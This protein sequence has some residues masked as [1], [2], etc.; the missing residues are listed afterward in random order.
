[1]TLGWRDTGIPGCCSIRMLGHQNAGRP[2]HWDVGMLEHQDSCRSGQRLQAQVPARSL[3]SCRVT[4]G[5]GTAGLLESGSPWGLGGPAVAGPME[6][7]SV[8]LCWVLPTGDSPAPLPTRDPSLPLLPHLSP[9]PSSSSSHPV[10][11]HPAS[12]LEP[13]PELP[14]WF[15]YGSFLIPVPVLVPVPVLSPIHSSTPTVVFQFWCWSQ[16]QSQSWTQSQCW[17]QS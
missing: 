5:Q 2:G 1:M 11:P 13:V 14:V 7:R 12:W 10:A 4:Q 3:G 9:H 6:H 15:Q 17:S 8:S 16:F